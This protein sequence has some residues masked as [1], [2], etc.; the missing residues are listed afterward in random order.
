MIP[1]ELSWTSKNEDNRI[2]ADVCDDNAFTVQLRNLLYRGEGNRNLVVS[3]IKEA[4]ILRIPKVAKGD[5]VSL[6]E[7]REA[8]DL[9]VNFTENVLIRL[10]NLSPFAECPKVVYLCDKDMSHINKLISNSR[11]DARTH[12]TVAENGS[13]ALLMAD[14]CAF[15]CSSDVI[16]I[17]GKAFRLSGP[18]IST[19]LKP[20]QGFLPSRD[21][22]SD[23]MAIMSSVTRFH[24]TQHLKLQENMTDKIS[25][26]CPLDL[27][28]G[29]PY[30]TKKAIKA[31]LDNPQNNLRVFENSRQIYGDT[32]DMLSSQ[33]DHSLG[34]YNK[35]QTLELYSSLITSALLMP[36]YTEDV[37]D[38][39]MD[40]FYEPQQYVPQ[41]DANCVLGRVLSVQR[42]DTIGSEVALEYAKY[43]QDKNPNL[44]SSISSEIPNPD[45]LGLASQA[46]NESIYD[47]KYR[48][49]WEFLVSLTAKDLSI[50]ITMQRADEL[51]D[52]NLSCGMDDNRK[53]AVLRHMGVNYACS[54]S[55]ADLDPKI[56]SSIEDFDKRW[57]QK[58]LKTIQAYRKLNCN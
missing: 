28:S 38:S 58:D 1:L 3:L 10:L 21:I 31:L 30:R 57:V 50:M 16:M 34:Q 37:A 6:E 47:F 11:P 24:L 5:T 48:K 43:L 8:L 13:F 41:L 39:K 45:N 42:L 32:V 25:T 49:M 12:K 53:M 7:Q 40:I 17:R 51:K 55:V 29:C 19:E 26:Y 14:Y 33:L 54:I 20:K 23:D 15:G 27:F 9:I 22:L 36:I 18:I 35:K 2:S 4:K 56:P 44:I 52:D 46:D